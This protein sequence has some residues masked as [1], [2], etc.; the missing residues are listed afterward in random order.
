MAEEKR[1]GE[2]LLL[3]LPLLM[4]RGGGGTRVCAGDRRRPALQICMLLAG[5][6]MPS[7][8]VR[9]GHGQVQGI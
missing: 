2:W 7:M 6:Y 3:W 9:M 8:G 5:S 4:V 1:G